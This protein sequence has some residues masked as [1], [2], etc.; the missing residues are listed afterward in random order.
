[1]AD[2]STQLTV[3]H[4]KLASEMF[5]S[6]KKVDLLTSLSLLEFCLVSISV[7]CEIL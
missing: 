3:D 2:D 5:L 1:M 6:E 4:V 7:L